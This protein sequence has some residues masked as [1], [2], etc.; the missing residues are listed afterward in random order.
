MNNLVKLLTIVIWLCVGFAAVLTLLNIAYAEDGDT[1][2]MTVQCLIAECDRC[3][4]DEEE[5][6]VAGMLW[7]IEKL[8]IAWNRNPHHVTKRTYSDQVEA[9]CAIFDERGT[10]YYKPRSTRIRSGSFDNPTHI[11]G[12]HWNRLRGIV[13]EFLAGKIYDPHPDAD[14]FGGRCD[15]DRARR[16]NWYLVATYCND[17]GSWCTYF[18]K[19]NTDL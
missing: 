5:R 14:Y 3:N 4:R 9:Y 2:L 11:D 1:E 7:V 12:E 10:R 16:N 19:V 15:V 13:K 6:E 18:W 17:D 8:R